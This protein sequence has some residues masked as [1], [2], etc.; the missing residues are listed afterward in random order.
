MYSIRSKFVCTFCRMFL[1]LWLLIFVHF[2]Q[3][4]IHLLIIEARGDTYPMVAQQV[5]NPD[6]PVCHESSKIVLVT[7][8]DEK[9]WKSEYLGLP[10]LKWLVFTFLLII[11][12]IL[13]WDVIIYSSTSV[14]DILLLPGASNE[15]IIVSLCSGLVSAKD[16]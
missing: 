1:I 6:H 9:T 10:L 4:L 2:L 5:Y 16:S 12:I 13:T 14:F 7:K 15:V 11:W 3:T 8:D